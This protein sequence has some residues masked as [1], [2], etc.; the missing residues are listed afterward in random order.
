MN[1]AT[2]GLPAMENAFVEASVYFPLLR[3]L[4]IHGR[5]HYNGNIAFSVNDF[6]TIHL[7]LKHLE[8]MNLST[9][10]LT[11]SDTD[12]ER[13][14]NVSPVTTMKILD[15]TSNKT[16]YRW[17]CY[18]A[19]KYPN[20]H[21]LNLRM[22]RLRSCFREQRHTIALFQQVPISFRRL[23]R[24]R[25]RYPRNIEGGNL[26]F[27]NM[28]NFHDMPLKYIFIVLSGPDINSSPANLYDA[29]KM[30]AET[31]LAKCSKTIESLYFGCNNANVPPVNLTGMENSL[32][33]LV[34]VNMIVPIVADIDTFLRAAPRLKSL[35][36]AYGDIKVKDELYKSERFE[37]QSFDLF[38]TIIT[39]DVLRFLSFH[40][41]NLNR[42]VLA[43][44]SVY[45]NFT[46]PGCQFIDMT[47]SRLQS[48]SLENTSFF[49]KDNKKCPENRNIT[50]ITRPVDDIHPKQEYDPNSLPVDI[51]EISDE[52]CCKWIEVSPEGYVTKEISEE[53]ASFIT[54]FVSNYEE[55]KKLTLEKALDTGSREPSEA[56]KDCCV[57]G[58]TKLKL[59]YVANYDCIIKYIWAHDGIRILAI[60]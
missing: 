4:M 26:L 32:C 13:I 19:R 52:D 1:I 25:I 55:N 18:L 21:T 49:I 59:G 22:E 34:N 20:L 54:K 14:P 11:L 47:Y 9:G 6:E 48:L 8:Y 38:G 45:G 39:S 24:L 43:H 16:D 56:W 51:G 35:R 28:I 30:I 17:L 40:C 3:R 23:T 33:N 15:I 57:F 29:P 12:L 31:F 5:I 37:L 27:M 41:R 44:T 10:F 7:R 58:Y 46:T 2:S 53:Q 36:L 50:L 42:M 60:P